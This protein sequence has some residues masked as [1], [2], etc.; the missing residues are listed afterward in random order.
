M[1]SLDI[2][3]WDVQHGNA[4]HI[5]TPNGKNI[6]IDLGDG[7]GT[8]LTTR[9]SPLLALWS[10]GVRTIN[11]LIVTHPH[12][13][14][15]D[16]I[17]NLNRFK[18]E[19]FVRPKWLTEL[20]IR[21]GNQSRDA[22]KISKYLEFGNDFNAPIA[23]GQD[24]AVASNWGGASFRLYL[25]TSLP[26]NHLNNHSIVTV[27]EYAGSKALIS[28]DNEAPSWKMLLQQPQF[29]AELST[30]DI[31]LAPH[32]GREAGFCAE[33]FEAGL[34]PRLTIISDDQHGSTSVTDKYGNRTRGWLVHLGSGQTEDRF[35]VTTR[36]DGTIQVSFGMNG[37]APYI[38]VKTEKG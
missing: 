12:R 25:D 8:L 22:D 17:E 9:F 24:T 10:S 20:D 37:S 7:E 4:T 35:C 27:A 29:R 23:P 18:V 2:T 11:Q 32:H 34:R 21:Q 31:L 36:C 38:Q 33:L 1:S 5:R 26:R 3:F 30:V 6:V 28:G 14:H 19:T 13:D 16:D 15:L